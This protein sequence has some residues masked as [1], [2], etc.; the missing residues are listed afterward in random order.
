MEEALEVLVEEHLEL[1]DLLVQTQPLTLAVAE[2]ELEVETA[3]MIL[4]M[5]VEVAVVEE[6]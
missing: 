3:Q 1:L 2:E 4:I 5:K 6:S